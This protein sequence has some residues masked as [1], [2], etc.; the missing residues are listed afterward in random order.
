MSR[1]EL[2]AACKAQQPGSREWMAA[3]V[4]LGRARAAGFLDAT[5][6]REKAEGLLKKQGQS[7]T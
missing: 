6:A 4:A 2:I 3:V 5:S 7:A 1:E